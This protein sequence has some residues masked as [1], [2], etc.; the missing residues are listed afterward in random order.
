MVGLDDFDRRLPWVLQAAK[1]RADDKQV[2]ETGVARLDIVERQKYASGEI[3]WLKNGGPTVIFTPR[4]HSVTT[5]NTVPQKIAKQMA[6]RIRLLKRNAAS[7]EKNDSSWFSERRSGRRQTMSAVETTI[8]KARKNGP[9]PDCVKLCTEDTTPERVRNVPKTVRQNAVTT[10]DTF[11]TFS[12]SFFSWIMT[13]CRN[14]VVTS[15]GM[16]AAF[17]TGSQAQ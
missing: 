13:E 14:A 12:M 2:V 16:K 6:S 7:R 4:T 9:R 17:S 11:H 8:T 15:Q 3:T 10:S 1:Y 5:G